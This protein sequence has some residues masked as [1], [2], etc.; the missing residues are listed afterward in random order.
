MRISTLSASAFV[1]GTAALDS[2]DRIIYDSQA[3]TL[4][5]DAD[6]NGPGG[7]VMFARIGGGKLLTNLDFVVT[8]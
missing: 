8:E 6:G 4:Y 5:Y 3:G 1:T 2:D 7:A